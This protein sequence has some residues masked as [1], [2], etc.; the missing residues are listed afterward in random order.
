MLG[1]EELVILMCPEKVRNIK[2]ENH[3]SIDP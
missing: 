2:S 3:H 1:D